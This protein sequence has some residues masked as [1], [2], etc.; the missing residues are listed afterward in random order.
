MFAECSAECS[1]ECRQ[2]HQLR[3]AQTLLCTD[4]R[5]VI[6]RNVYQLTTPSSFVTRVQ[7]GE[8]ARALLQI[9]ETWGAPQNVVTDSAVVE[10]LLFQLYP[11]RVCSGVGA[12][13]WS[14]W[15]IM[16]TLDQADTS[17]STEQ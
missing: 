2:D 17:S 3:K 8:V 15:H 11:A 1:A 4:A 9:C 16:S 14:M 6:H 5:H 13:R 7:A 12:A 10:S